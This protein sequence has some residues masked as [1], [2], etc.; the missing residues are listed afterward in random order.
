[1]IGTTKR[2]MAALPSAWLRRNVFH[3]CEGGPRH[4][5]GDAGLAEGENAE[6]DRHDADGEVHLH[7]ELWRNDNPEHMIAAPTAMTVMVCPMPQA[8]ISVEPAMLCS[9]LTSSKW[10]P[11]GRRRWHAASQARSRKTATTRCSGRFRSLHTRHDGYSRPHY[12]GFRP[13]AIP[14]CAASGTAAFGSSTRHVVMRNR[15]PPNVAIRVG[16]EIE[17]MVAALESMFRQPKAMTPGRYLSRRHSLS[18]ATE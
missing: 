4:I 17:R 8:P 10:Q 13:D 15:G 2:S 18:V 7:A 11:R 5:L 14:T 12:A 3:P 1:M 16:A 6:Q 9:R